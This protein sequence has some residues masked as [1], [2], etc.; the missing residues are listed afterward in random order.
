MD[1][2]SLK[3]TFDNTQMNYDNTRYNNNKKAGEE[4]TSA[5]VEQ[6]ADTNKINTDSL[7]RLTYNKSENNDKNNSNPN[8]MTKSYEEKLKKV[9]EEAND[10]LKMVNKK[11]SYKI[12]DKTNEI[13]VKII[14]SDTGDIIK[15]IPPEKNLDM[16]AKLREL[17][18]I[19]IDERR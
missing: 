11:F 19:M 9:I 10:K 7:D 15:E 13:M 5:K 17:A 1:G 2:N 6:K 8:H 16:I 14:N 4:N 3:L 18:G 12:H